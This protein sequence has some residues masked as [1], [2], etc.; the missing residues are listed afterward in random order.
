MDDM[1]QRFKQKLYRNGCTTGSYYSQDCNLFIVFSFR[2]R[3]SYNTHHTHRIIHKKIRY[4]FS[5]FIAFL[6]SL[7]SSF[8]LC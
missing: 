7:S 3:V 5:N 8:V 1:L 2:N 4:I 6:L